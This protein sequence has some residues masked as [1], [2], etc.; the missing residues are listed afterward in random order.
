P[1]SARAGSE[2]PGARCHHFEPG[3]CRSCTLLAPPRPHQIA[4]GRSRIEALL[5]PYA[6]EG[7]VWQ[8]PILGPA[9]GFRAR[10]KMALAGTAQS[11]ILGLPWQVMEGLTAD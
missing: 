9:A 11:S 7:M 1:R 3:E 10:A 5:A 2:P 8:E 6:R 4:A